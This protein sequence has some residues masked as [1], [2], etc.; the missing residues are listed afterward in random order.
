MSTKLRKHGESDNLWAKDGVAGQANT[1][2]KLNYIYKVYSVLLFGAKM[3]VV[4][5]PEK[6]HIV[7]NDNWNREEEDMDPEHDDVPVIFWRFVKNLNWDEFMCGQKTNHLNMPRNTLAHTRDIF[8]K[9]YGKL[10]RNFIA[11]R[12]DLIPDVGK[13]IM[14]ASHFI[15]LG[16]EHYV[17]ALNDDEL[18]NNVYSAD[19]YGDFNGSLPDDW[20][21]THIFT[22]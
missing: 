18:V 15:A 3:Q 5:I 8:M 10:I 11:A 14:L 16:N 13:C 2:S 19:L 12:G 9:H 20:R 4:K 21:Y 17:Q 7:S 1:N 22:S 6:F